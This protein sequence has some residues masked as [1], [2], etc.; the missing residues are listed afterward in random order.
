MSTLYPPHR[1]TPWHVWV[2]G[3]LALLWNGSGAYTI[4][5]AQAGRLLDVSADEAA[6]YAAQ[7]LWFVVATDIALVAAVAAAVA[8]L[9]RSRT[10]GW[11]F[12]ISVVAVFVT[13]VY[14][15]AAGTSRVLVDRGALIVTSIIAVLAVLQ[16]VYALAMKE[17]CRSC[18]SCRTTRSCSGL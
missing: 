4:M 15:L 8:L 9:L 16:L 17:A 18:V 3:V 14:D 12:A 13:N 6:Y 1:R 2:V 10:A 11:L 7:P 5:M